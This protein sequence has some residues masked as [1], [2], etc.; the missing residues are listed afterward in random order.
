M[1]KIDTTYQILLEYLKEHSDRS[2]LT[3]TEI[4]KKLWFDHHQKVTHRLKNL[5]K[6]WYIRK[7]FDTWWY[8][9]FEV[10]V[11]DSVSLPVFGSAL[12][13]HKGGAVVDEY[14]EETMTFPTSL[15]WGSQDYSDY[16]FVKAKWDSMNPYIEDGDMVLIKKYKMGREV[17]KKVLVA[18]EGVLKIK[19]VQKNNNAY[20]LFSTNADKLEILWTDEVSVI[21]YVS[22]VIKDM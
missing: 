15:I 18:H 21:W 5:E 16:F 2:S 9:V 20:F 6:W 1:S 10:P 8:T 17:D 19:I 13:G 14:P 3:V 11:T 7:N 4:Q 12:C 22:K